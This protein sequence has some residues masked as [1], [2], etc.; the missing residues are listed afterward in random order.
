MER[1]VYVQEWSGHRVRE[2][3]RRAEMPRAREGWI[4][5]A[6]YLPEKVRTSFWAR[7]FGAA[8]HRWRW[9]RPFDVEG[10]DVLRLGDD[11]VPGAVRVMGELRPL[12]PNA[13]PGPQAL[14]EDFWCDAPRPWR[15]V[16]G[17]DALLAPD[18]GGAPL[19][20]S[21]GLAPLI[22]APPVVRRAESVLLGLAAPDLRLL[23][24]G[25]QRAAEGAFVTV[26][27]GARAEVIG[28]QKPL[29]ESAR[30]FPLG[31][32]REA[33]ARPRRVIGDEDGVRLVIRVDSRV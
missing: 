1:H 23:P 21:C 14:F 12:D 26:R 2:R 22:V 9:R 18:D 19:V 24:E 27:A 8:P 30:H 29:A 15:V 13:P 10:R 6:P 17:V 7:L 28:L 25:V 4:R 16:R 3:H 11:P 33:A 20:V 32:Y 5:S 31:G